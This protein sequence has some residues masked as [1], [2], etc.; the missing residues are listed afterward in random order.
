MRIG[1]LGNFGVSYSSET[2]HAASL[3]QL[4]HTVLRCQETVAT[5]DQI[6]ALDVDTLV[7]IK[8]HGW[9]TPSITAAIDELRKRRIPIVTYHLDLYMPLADRWRQYQHDPYLTQLDWFF[10]VDPQMAEW[11][12]VHTDVQGRFLPAG[13]YGDE[14]YISDKPSPHANDVVFVGARGYHPEHPWRP[15]LIDWLR[16]TYGPRFTHVGGDGDTGTLRGDDLN[17]MYASSKIAVGDTLCPNFNYV[18]YASDRMFECPGRGGFSLF[19]AIP[20]TDDWYH[21][22]TEIVRYTYGDFDGL[23][24]L[25][26]YYLDHDDEREKIRHGGHHRT[27]TDHTYTRRWQKILDT[28]FR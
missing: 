9:N 23:K 28:V 4:G 24:S 15:Q 18:G 13:V 16:A 21:N 2:H 26:D 20:G 5:A 11:L 8:T 12:S 6:A 27:A 7:W 14:C 22:G 3:E 25:I 19:P 17:R 1:F 10:T